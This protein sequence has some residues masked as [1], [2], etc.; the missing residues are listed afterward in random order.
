MSNLAPLKHQFLPPVSFSDVFST[1]DFVP[2]LPNYARLEMVPSHDYLRELPNFLDTP[3]TFGFSDLIFE[4]NDSL[5]GDF[6]VSIEEVF[7]N[8]NPTITSFF[9]A[10]MIDIPL[11]FRKSKSLNYLSASNPQV[12]L[13]NMLTR[14]GRRAYTARMYTLALHHI[15]RL[16]QQQLIDDRDL[17]QWR[18]LHAG[19]V[20]AKYSP[21]EVSFRQPLLSLGKSEDLWLDLY[22]QE[23]EP[24]V[25]ATDEGNWVHNFFYD[26]LENYKP[27]FS[28]YVR[29]VDKMKRKHS[30]GKTGKYV[31]S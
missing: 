1:Y 26:E 30:R 19:F 11:C 6:D 18:S 24:E 14:H 2:L 31:I 15:G 16:F 8:Q 4:Y 23:H 5:E 3:K 12:R 21:N 28:F 17:L 20:R 10:Q 27:T 25:Y 29:K 9:A 22:S 7:L 13:I